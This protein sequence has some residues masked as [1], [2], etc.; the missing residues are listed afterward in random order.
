[1]KIDV[2]RF[3]SETFIRAS[4]EGYKEAF[5]LSNLSNKNTEVD[6]WLDA[7]DTP[8]SI[9][10]LVYL[11]AQSRVALVVVHLSGTVVNGILTQRGL[12]MVKVLEEVFDHHLYTHL[13]EMSSPHII[14]YGM[15]NPGLVYTE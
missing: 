12:H 4:I 10:S 5:P 2:T 14:V 1:M 6:V 13:S 15:L 7:E 11:I 8:D 3:D 9:R